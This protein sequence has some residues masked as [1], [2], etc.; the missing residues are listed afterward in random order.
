MAR[1]NG[2]NLSKQERDEVA[3][4]LIRNIHNSPTTE[5]A[6]TETELFLEFC[7]NNEKL[8]ERFV[9]YFETYCSGIWGNWKLIS[10]EAGIP[11]TNNGQEG[12]NRKIKLDLDREP[13][14]LLELSE[15]FLKCISDLGQEY[16]AG[17]TVFAIK[18]NPTHKEL[19]DGY[20]MFRATLSDGVTP[21]Y[22]VFTKKD[23]D[24]NTYYV[25]KYPEIDKYY[26]F[27]GDETVVIVYV[28]NTDVSTCTCIESIKNG[29]CNH[30]I[31][32]MICIKL[33]ENCKIKLQKLMVTKQKSGRKP[34][35]M[36]RVLEREAESVG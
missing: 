31:A 7:R 4:F 19:A 27:V 1:S 2:Y 35:K 25:K 22:R 30:Q 28:V 29:L 13:Q 21:K 23:G 8:G 16:I 9:T 32:V 34:A 33:Y 11:A 5:E 6:Q 14:T 10:S 15:M 12:Y 36:S 17:R 18:Y 3:D 24:A 20:N 26:R